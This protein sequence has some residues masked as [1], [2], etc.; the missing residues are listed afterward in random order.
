MKIKAGDK[1]KII[2]GKDQGKEG[3]VKKAFRS[4]KTVMVEGVNLYKKH[5]K[6]KGDK[7]PGGIITLNRPLPVENVKFICPKCGQSVRVGYKIEKDQKKYRFCKK[8]KEI[9]N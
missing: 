5:Q 7:A 1:V 8:C 2:K 3:I 9:I 4:E 6:P